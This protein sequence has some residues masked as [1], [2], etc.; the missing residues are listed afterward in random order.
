MWWSPE[1]VLAQGRGRNLLYLCN[2]LVTTKMQPV[3]WAELGN[4]SLTALQWGFGRELGTQPHT[5][6]C[7][8]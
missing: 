5:P 3:D 8:E 6:S 1:A 2:L 7:L 4:W